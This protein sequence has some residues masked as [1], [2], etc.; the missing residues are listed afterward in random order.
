MYVI[1][2]LGNPGVQYEPTRH[3][4]GFRV[5]EALS[6]RCKI[7]LMAGGEL[8]DIGT[9]TYQEAGFFIAQPRTFMNNSGLAVDALVEE[10]SIS[11]DQLL[12]VCDDCN[13][14]LGK[15]R[16]RRS[17][18]DGG[19]N[20]LASIIDALGTEDFLR[21]RVGIGQ[22]PP[23]VDL[24]DYVLEAFDAHEE[25]MIE[26]AIISATDAILCMLTEGLDVAMNTFN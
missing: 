6:S 1:V 2:G 23:D 26:G 21:L 8:Y 18:S 15:I 4:V 17:G 11:I 9:G 24:V 25:E 12:V 7:G 10:H 14:P 5:I 16:L 20:G 19:H 22:P 3:N 13:L